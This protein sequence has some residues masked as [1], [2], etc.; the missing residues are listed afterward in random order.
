MDEH[1]PEYIR[2]HGPLEV[3]L[4]VL[5][6]QDQISTL[7]GEPAW[8]H[9]ERAAKTLA[10]EGNLRVVLTLMRPKTALREHQTAGATTIQ[11]LSGRLTVSALGREIELVEG[12]MV[13]LDR[14]VVHT[15]EA[16]NEA[17]FLLTIAE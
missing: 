2:E 6:F 4:R 8:E 10:K 14:E 13:A 3:P 11:C 15:V 5:R 9:G 16:A 17:A 7:K 1:V 12:E